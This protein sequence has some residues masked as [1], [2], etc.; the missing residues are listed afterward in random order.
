MH[1]D[2]AKMNECLRLCV[3]FTPVELPFTARSSLSQPG[4]SACWEA[5]THGA[6]E[7]E[8]PSRLSP[9]VAK[10]HEPEI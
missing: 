1:Q 8:P 4:L 6:G 3:G 2:R 10:C 9:P 5:A 7:S